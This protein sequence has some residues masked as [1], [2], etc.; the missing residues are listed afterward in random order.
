MMNEGALNKMRAGNIC[1]DTFMK[2]RRFFFVQ[3][4]YVCGSAIL[5]LFSLYA[6]SRP[7]SLVLDCLVAHA[8][9]NHLLLKR[10][11]M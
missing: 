3:M 2:G 1:T 11:G 10:S 5:H 9:P 7:L 8:N 4:V 6:I